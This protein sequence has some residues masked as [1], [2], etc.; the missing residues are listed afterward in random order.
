M[1]LSKYPSTVT[2]PN[3][4][5]PYPSILVFLQQRFPFVA[6]QLWEQ[7]IAEG[8][9]LD[10]QSTPITLETGYAPGKRIFYFRE[11][12]TEPVI[13]FS[14]KILFQDD[15][16]LVACKP[17][18]LPVTPGGRYVDECLLNRLRSSS[19]I[20]DLAPL[21]RIDRETAGIVLFSVNMKTRSLY[22]QLFLHGSVEKTYQALSAHVPLGDKKE[23]IV[24]DRIVRGEPWFRMKTG[25]G[26]VNARS[27]INLV[28]VKENR[29]RFVLRPISGKTHQLRI[30]MSWLG[31]GILN[32]RYYPELQPES[33]DN[34]NTPLQLVAKMVR[35]QD[36]VTG[37]NREFVSG[38]ELLL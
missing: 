34:F 35:F 36:P 14:E 17:H 13:P 16:I 10:E 19:G 12:D 25:P 21:H 38:R 28:E 7:R 3:T 26:T 32:D 11:V 20:H 27:M 2:M 33:E 5:Q 8:K 30:H 9:V 22:S 24:A 1:G 31:F 15:E 18:F 23:W 6:T 29:A 37:E 4:E